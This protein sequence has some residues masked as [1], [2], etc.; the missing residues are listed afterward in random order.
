MTSTEPLTVY[1]S[2]STVIDTEYR[3][4]DDRTPSE[5]VVEALATAA[6]VEPTDLPPLYDFVDPDALDTLFDGHHK[7]TSGDTI[8]SFRVNAWNVFV[9]GDGR[10]HVCDASESTELEPVF[11][12]NR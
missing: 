5:A 7:A 10:V 9:R 2:C 6:G 12:S 1:H 11:A 8:L 3:R 4:E